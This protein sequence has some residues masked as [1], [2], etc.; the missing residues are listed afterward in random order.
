MKAGD[1]RMFQEAA[2]LISNPTLTLKQQG[3][4]GDTIE[5]LRSVTHEDNEVHEPRGQAGEGEGREVGC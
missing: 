1:A 5:S 2:E 4:E 3:L